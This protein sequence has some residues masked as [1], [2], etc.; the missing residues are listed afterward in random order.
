MKARLEKIADRLDIP[1]L[2]TARIAQWATLVLIAVAALNT[3]A[4]YLG[5]SI[6]INLSSNRWIE[7]QWYL[8]AVMILL[9]GARGIQ[10]DSH[11]RIDILHERL[12]PSLR[13]WINILGW[14]FLFLPFCMW[15]MFGGW[16]M[17]MDS[18]HLRETSS[19]PDGL[20]RYP[21]KMLI[22]ITFFLLSLQGIASIL[23]S[24]SALRHTDT[25]ETTHV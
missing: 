20:I 13:S 17:A 21:L 3:L 8:F 1:G 16:H 18:W 23:R 10:Q 5:S 19:D 15:S 25:R 2:Y 12:R 14:I 11:V 7:L 24:I 22:P 6:G 9:S 4:R